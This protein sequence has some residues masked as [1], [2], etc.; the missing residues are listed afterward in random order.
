[1]WFN[2]FLVIAL[3]GSRFGRIDPL[4]A[5]STVGNIQCGPSRVAA[6]ATGTLEGQR[7][8]GIPTNGGDTVDVDYEHEARTLNFL[9][10]LVLGAILGAGVA[11]LTAPASGPKTRRRI[12]RVAGDIRHSAGD[13]IEDFAD[14]VRSK[15]EDAY[16][17]ARKRI[18]G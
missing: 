5:K 6:R 18:A 13:Q 10:G 11:L 2:G 16:K 17:S 4:R 14:D 3:D 7:A 12:R 15:V 9:S 1:V 8:N